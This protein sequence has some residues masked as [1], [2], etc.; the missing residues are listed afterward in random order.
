MNRNE[1]L[2]RGNLPVDLGEVL[3]QA[4]L[5]GTCGH[6]PKAGSL[7][8]AGPRSDIGSQFGKI[9]LAPPGLGLGQAQ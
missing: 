8:P 7:G 2:G 3:P 5:G 9:R 4:L 1:A 6:H